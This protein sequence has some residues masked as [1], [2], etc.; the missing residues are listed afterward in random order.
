MWRKKEKQKKT[1]RKHIIM[2]SYV[3]NEAKLH[4]IKLKRNLVDLGFQV[5]LDVD[6]IT[7]GTSFKLLFCFAA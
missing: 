5:F 2:I 1:Q 4:A 6:E 3:Q 7:V